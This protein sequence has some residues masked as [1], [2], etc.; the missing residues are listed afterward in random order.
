MKDKLTLTSDRSAL[1]ARLATASVED[2]LQ[3]QDKEELRYR[4]GYQITQ[5]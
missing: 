1:I 3:I 5:L 2:Q 4:T